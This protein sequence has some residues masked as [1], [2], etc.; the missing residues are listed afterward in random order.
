MRLSQL[1]LMR[2]SSTLGVACFL[3]S[4]SEVIVMMQGHAPQSMATTNKVKREA[5]I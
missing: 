3:S 5:G 4:C 2:L 1:C